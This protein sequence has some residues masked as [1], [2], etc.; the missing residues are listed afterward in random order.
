MACMHAVDDGRPRTS[1]GHVSRTSAVRLARRLTIP[2]D[3]VRQGLL[4]PHLHA[5]SAYGI[6]NE[7]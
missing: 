6:M 7:N 4:N 3:R 5:S 2:S 1:P